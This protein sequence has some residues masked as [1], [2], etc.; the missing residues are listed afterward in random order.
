VRKK[1]DRQKEG[2]RWYLGLPRTHE[3]TNQNLWKS[4]LQSSLW[5]SLF[6]NSK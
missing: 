5:V 4:I 2:K 6:W 3:F 1:G